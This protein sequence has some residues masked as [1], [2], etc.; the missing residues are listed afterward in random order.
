MTGLFPDESKN[1]AKLLKFLNPGKA[2][3]R[4]YKIQIL[5]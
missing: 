5:N 4:D 3:F 1:G 2:G